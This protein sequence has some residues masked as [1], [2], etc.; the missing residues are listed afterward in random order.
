MDNPI[1]IDEINFGLNLC[2]FRESGD[3]NRCCVIAFGLNL[4]WFRESGDFNRCCVIALSVYS[5]VGQI[6]SEYNVTALH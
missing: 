6:T 1:H 2:W 3:F 4:C 5:E